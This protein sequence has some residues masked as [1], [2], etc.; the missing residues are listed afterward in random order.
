MDVAAWLRGLGLERYEK[1]FRD[2]AVDAEVLPDLTDA[3][4]EK[5]G[6]V[7]G[8]R[9]KLLN[10]IRT[11]RKAPTV[12]D[13]R[14]PL[15]VEKT[16]QRGYASEPP[17]ERRQLTIMFIDLV[18]STALSSRH[19]PEEMR[20]VIRA[21]QNAVAGEVLRFEG[22]VAKFMGDGV[23]AYFGWPQAHEDEAERAVR[24]GLA[25]VGEVSKLATPAEEV[26][27]A[28]VGI[29]TGLVVVGDLVGE[30][31]AQ[32]EAVVGETPNLA[33]RL[34]A[35]ANPGGV[36][37]AESTR[38][39]LGDLFEL[40]ELPPQTLRG[41]GAL[42]RPFQIKGEGRAESRF[43]ALHAG[44]LTPLVGREQELAL[45]LERWSRAK[46]G[47]GQVV[48]LS[49]EPG[50]GKSRIV[51][52]LRE[53]LAN[54]PYTPLSHY[55]SP[56][57]T[58]SALYP[59]IGLLERAA[60]FDREDTAEARLDKLQALLAQSTQQI[61]EVAPLLASLLG[62][63][64]DG[65]YPPL[66]LTPQRQKQLTLEA[67]VGQLVGL[68]K[69][70]PVLAVYED[71]HWVDPST[72]ELLELLV[73]RIQRLPALLLIT[74]RPE[75]RPPWTGHAHVTQL[76][77]SRLTR[78]HGS[79]M[80]LSVIGGKALPSE[81]LDQIVART[82]GV[83]LFVEELTK[84]VVESRLLRDAGDHF[85]LI[86]PM[87]YFAIPT[88]LHDSLMARLDHLAPVKEVAQIAAVIGREFSYEILAAMASI[89]PGK[90]QHALQQLADAEL[91]FRRGIP[92][93]ATYTFKHALVQDAAYQSLLKRTRQHYHWQVAKLLESRFPQIVE[94][95]PELLAHHCAE[96][97]SIEQAI[98]YLNKAGQQAARRSANQ[99]VIAHSTR[100]LELLGKLPETADRAAIELPLQK[101]RGAAL[102]ATRGYGATEVGVA[103]DRAW[104][105]CQLVGESEDVCPVLS[106]VWLFNLTRANH[107]VGRK[108]AEELVTHASAAN[109]RDALMVGHVAAAISDLHRG[110]LALARPHFEQ[111]I[112][113]HENHPPMM[114]SFRFG[115]DYAAAGYAYAAWC[116]WLLGRPDRALW[117]S[118]QGLAVVD[119]EKHLYTVSRGFYWNSVLHQ[120]RGEWSTVKQRAKVARKS[121]KEQGFALVVS[122]S[123]IMEGA[124]RAA[125]GD[126]EAGIRVMRDALEAYRATGARFQRPHHMV[127]LAD[128]L[129]TGGNVDEALAVLAEAATLIDETDERY[130]E[131]EVY[132][133]RGAL[134]LVRSRTDR[135][136]T[137]HCLRTALDIS[138][139]QQS[140]SLELHAAR[141]LAAVLAEDGQR[142]Q[143]HDLLTA[144]Y[145]TFTEGADTPAAESS[146]L[147]LDALR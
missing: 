88:T 90:L 109:D 73:E 58:N 111:A 139:T 12:Q 42:V 29:A 44:G 48:L 135:A 61:N 112:A 54:E 105:L 115:V 69:Q 43:E 79:A 87:R 101:L 75:F 15:S 74:F 70:R 86:G 122:A 132:R 66:D 84:A 91:I 146:R 106:G 6:V 55:C 124:A 45:L 56:Y 92:P 113:V 46:E 39:L 120:L 57:H 141:D 52:T 96:S 72:L 25:I 143:A 94:A 1:A 30:G 51:R 32:E 123:R 71:V 110:E 8:H 20:E 118:E 33:A 134:L 125:L 16:H 65:R 138:R 68:A 4:L 18:G 36:I 104:A 9:K 62:I 26:L 24:A 19:D 67:L 37:V 137:I 23:L 97:G 53:R 127:L 99:E 133:V 80:V 64:A 129:R 11:L 5:I 136:E 114:H 82:D 108:A 21:Y 128:A 10:A 107:A 50:I 140:K 76:S 77:L 116:E 2:N 130:Y 98:C 89:D 78:R 63:P 47:D 14:A 22:H 35:L 144:V 131:A 145:E 119:R 95:Q 147:L 13:A 81:V 3:D 142:Q 7:L 103:Y 93:D 40:E 83:P 31:A 100:A 41:F 34:Q 121:A 85:E 17:S 38:R 59:V 27:A 126:V 102:M 117:L 28:R 49:G 60:R